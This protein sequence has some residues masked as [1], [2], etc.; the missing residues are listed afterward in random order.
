MGDK[1]RKK[2]E[3]GSRKFY[4]IDYENVNKY[5]FN[6]ILKLDEND[7]VIIFYSGNADKMTF[8]L[9]K[10]ILDSKANIT[11]F[12][13]SCG[14]KNAL[15][16][17]LSSYIGYLIGSKKK[18]RCFIVSN[19]RG[20]E[21]I[22][23]FW[24]K[25]GVKVEIISGIEDENNSPAVSKPASSSTINKEAVKRVFQGTKMSK[26]KIDF[27]YEILSSNMNQ[28]SVLLFKRKQQINSELCKKFGNSETKK[29]Y[30]KL[31]PFMK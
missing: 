10:Q 18:C 14:G 25:Q 22:R 2:S 20:F 8:D 15:D 30:E 28:T 26:D 21:Y 13:I 27:I 3:K 9:H 19:D 23:D 7:N 1:K 11:Y 6:G 31:K 24:K 29:I 17:Q 16:F 5:G 4:L 12:E